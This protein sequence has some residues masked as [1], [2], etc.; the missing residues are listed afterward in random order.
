MQIAHVLFCRLSSFPDDLV[1]RILLLC[2]DGLYA[3]AGGHR[4]VVFGDRVKF[5][6]RAGLLGRG[7]G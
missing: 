1:F 6:V 2:D 3:R 4:V 7:L 5:S